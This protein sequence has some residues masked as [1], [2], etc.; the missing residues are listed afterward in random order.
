M[1]ALAASDPRG[2]RFDIALESIGRGPG[3]PGEHQDREAGAVGLVLIQAEEAHHEGDHHHPSPQPHEAPE[4]AGQQADENSHDQRKSARFKV[5]GRVPPYT[6][7]K[8]NLLNR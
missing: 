8:P 3:E 6:A 2:Q 4:G 7:Q 1:K 5:K